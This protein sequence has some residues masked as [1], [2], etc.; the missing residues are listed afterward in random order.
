M[1]RA[2][3]S[4]AYNGART[5]VSDFLDEEGPG[6][7]EGALWTR[8]KLLSTAF[9]LLIVVP[10][11]SC[12]WAVVRQELAQLSQLCGNEGFI[13]SPLPQQVTVS[14]RAPVEARSNGVFAAALHELSY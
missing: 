9:A 8:G 12:Y 4:W 2:V 11:E 14:V 6:C 13:C 1:P 10:P 3:G 5:N 7:G